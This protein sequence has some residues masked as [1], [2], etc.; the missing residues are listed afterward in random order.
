[1]GRIVHLFLEQDM[2]CTQPGLVARA[3]AERDFDIAD[4][5]PGDV[6]AFLNAKCDRIKVIAGIDEE[7]SYGVMG[8]YRSPHGRIDEG[9]VQYIADAFKGGA[10]KMT[11]AIKRSL[12]NKLH[13]AEMAATA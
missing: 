8:Y 2:R 1:M 13:P 9:A 5:K 10:F 4:L 7:D 3:K 11:T 6:L 12:H